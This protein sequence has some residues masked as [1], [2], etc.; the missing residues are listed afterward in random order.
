[1]CCSANDLS[2]EE[3][4]LK[5]PYVPIPCS[6]RGTPPSL[7]ENSAGRIVGPWRAVVMMHRKKKANAKQQ[8]QL[9]PK[10][11]FQIAGE[12]QGATNLR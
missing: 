6:L 4:R 3:F 12:C 11:R 5:R 1:M 9:G 2:A 7:P 8:A 10:S